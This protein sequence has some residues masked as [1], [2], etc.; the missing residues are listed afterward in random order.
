MEAVEG[1]ELAEGINNQIWTP[2]PTQGR[3]FQ[4]IFFRKLHD[5]LKNPNNSLRKTIFKKPQFY[6]NILFQSRKCLLS[7][8]SWA[9]IKIPA[10]HLFLIYYFILFLTLDVTIDFNSGGFMVCL[11]TPGFQLRRLL[12]VFCP[13]QFFA[14]L[15]LV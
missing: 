8:R 14:K 11:K 1:V 15:E 9:V 2:L 13:K 10:L 3:E 12:C 4:W 5:L 6:L 7:F